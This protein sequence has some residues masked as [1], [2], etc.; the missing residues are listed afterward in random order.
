MKNQTFSKK[1]CDLSIKN[2]WFFQ[3]LKKHSCVKKGLALHPNRADLAYRHAPFTPP[4]PAFLLS[5]TFP[6]SPP[7]LI[8]VVII[9]IIIMW[10]LE[11]C[12]VIQN[13][14]IRDTQTQDPHK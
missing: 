14:T 2:H 6:S 11:I 10:G 3:I 12:T 8:V 1:S 4:T 9:I 5:P 7:P 13:S